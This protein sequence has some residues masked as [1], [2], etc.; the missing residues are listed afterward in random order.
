M[1]KLTL[2]TL[3]II[4]ITC[5]IAIGGQG[6]CT[7]R[8]CAGC[9]AG[10]TCSVCSAPQ[11]KVRGPP[12]LSEQLNFIQHNDEGYM[13]LSLSSSYTIGTGIALSLFNYIL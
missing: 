2:S 1:F 3:I 10:C 12:A 7:C 13:E 11:D 6:D 8:C 9:P 4:L 5:D